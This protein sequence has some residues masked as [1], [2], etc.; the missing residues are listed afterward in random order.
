[1]VS[2]TGW[3]L[4]GSADTHVGSICTE[5]QLPKGTLQGVLGAPTEEPGSHASPQKVLEAP[6]EEAHVQTQCGW[7]QQLIPVTCKPIS[8]FGT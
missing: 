1:M 7:E 3:P 5:S 8:L 6:G 2:G 4:Y